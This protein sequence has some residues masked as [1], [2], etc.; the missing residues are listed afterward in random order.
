M[1]QNYCKRTTREKK[2][3]KNIERCCA[4]SFNI[5]NHNSNNYRY[6]RK[7]LFRGQ[8]R[9]D[10]DS[11]IQESTPFAAQMLKLRRKLQW[12][13]AKTVRFM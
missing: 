10:W 6:R 7:R 12:N 9:E 3:K 4:H 2:G 11:G 1:C 8:A 5:N 13:M